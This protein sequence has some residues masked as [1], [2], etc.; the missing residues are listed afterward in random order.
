M[1]Q[2]VITSFAY[3]AG[4]Q[5]AFWLPLKRRADFR[6]RAAVCFLINL[7][8]LAAYIAVVQQWG[9]AGWNRLALCAGYFVWAACA[10]KICTPLKWSGSFYCGT[11]IVL[12]SMTAYEVWRG[13]EALLHRCLGVVLPPWVQLITVALYCVLLRYTAARTMPDEG[14]YRIGPRQL[15]SGVLLGCIFVFQFTSLL[16]AEEH[17]YSVQL[18]ASA[19]LTQL[20]CLTLLFLQTELF[21]KSAMQKE[22]DTL[23]ILYERQRRQYLVARQNVQLI[24][25]KCHELKVQI[26]DLRRMNPAVAQ[27]SLRQAEAAVSAYDAAADTGNEV[28]D[29]VLTEKTMLCQADGIRLH[30]VAD[31][32]SLRFMEAGDLYTLFSNVLELAISQAKSEPQPEHRMIDL[33]VVKRQ[34]FAVINVAAPAAAAE[35]K[36]DYLLKVVRQVVDR[37]SGMLT[38][39]T[40][41]GFYKIKILFPEKSM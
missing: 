30:S 5:L 16:A 13:L 12:T 6:R 40:S 4:A 3:M 33:V 22:M 15:T 18:M 11:W 10:T 17:A 21:K 8:A 14:S 29:V 7:A 2:L 34:G 32:G 28:L 27:E 35:P 9:L 23:N 31:G 41:G 19:L 24:N 38:A 1:T 37:Y 39:E 36:E 20:Y 26:A 25:K